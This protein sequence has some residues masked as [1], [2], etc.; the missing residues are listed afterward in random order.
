MD[1]RKLKY[2][3]VVCEEKNITKA[4][5]RL[6]VSQPSLSVALQ[7]LEAELELP[8]LVRD[9]KH[10]VLT[11]EGAILQRK[12]QGVLQ[13]A[14]ALEQTM[15]DL[16]CQKERTLKLA[17]PSTAGAWLWPVLLEDF[18]KVHPEIELHVEDK[19][20]YDILRELMLD[21]LELGYGVLEENNNQEIASKTVQ[22]GELSLLLAADDVLAGKEEIAAEELAGR[23]VVMY[24]KGAS[25]AEGRFLQL[26]QDKQ[27]AVRLQYVEEQATVFNLVA[28]GLG[29]AVIL[30]E[31]ELIMHNRRLCSRPLAEHISFKTGFFWKKERYLSSGAREL[32]AFFDQ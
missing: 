27:V 30:D 8:L 23:L 1:L 29:L 5:Q 18:H 3:L 16:R 13:Q 32:L 12:A 22:E 20:T 7:R 24:R 17:F 6:H 26:L 31:T 2:F 14:D 25:Y 28:Q 15:L 4:A 9:N 10:V 11:R 21:E 19:S